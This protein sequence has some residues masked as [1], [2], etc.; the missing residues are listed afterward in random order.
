MT[1]TDDGMNAANAT[2]PLQK[3]IDYIRPFTGPMTVSFSLL[4]LSVFLSLWGTPSSVQHVHVNV[5]YRDLDLEHY[6][7]N[8]RCETYALLPKKDNQ[9]ARIFSRV[10]IA[11]ACLSIPMVVLEAVIA[12]QPKYANCNNQLAFHS[13]KLMNC[14]ILLLANLVVLPNIRY[15]ILSKTCCTTDPVNLRNNC[16]IFLSFIGFQMFNVF[17][18]VGNSMTKDNTVCSSM[19]YVDI[20]EHIASFIGAMLQTMLLVQ[21]KGYPPNNF[22]LLK[23]RKKVITFIFILNLGLWLG[24][25]FFM[26]RVRSSSSPEEHI[27]GQSFWYFMVDILC[28]ISIFY[29]FHSATEAFHISTQIGWIKMQKWY[30]K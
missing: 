15:N 2:L 20:A 4:S 17:N 3:W 21:L 29:R 1:N 18:V 6:E 22:Q 5:S 13:L 11:G 30:L 10:L 26:K 9:P 8:E 16:L 27:Y 7:N 14:V 24:D 19:R 28:P 12:F 25:C 23:K